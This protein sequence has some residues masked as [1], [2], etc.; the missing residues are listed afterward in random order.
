MNGR[1]DTRRVGIAV[2]SVIA[3]FAFCTGASAEQPPLR[4]V[5]TLDSASVQYGDPVEATVEVDYRPGTI[6]PASI[7]IEPSF[8]PYVATS[9]PVVRR[10]RP[11][12]F[13]STFTLLCLTEGCLPTEGPR[14]LHLEP[15]TV[16]AG[17]GAGTIRASGTWPTL[18]VSSR[19]TSADLSGPVRFRSPAGPPPPAYSIRPSVLTGGLILAAAICALAA[20]AILARELTKISLRSQEPRLSRLDLAIAYVRDSARRSGADRR[21]ALSLLAEATDE[22]EPLLAASAAEAAWAR[23]SPSPVGA[24]ELADRAAHTREVAE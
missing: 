22:R 12:V 10:P 3:L 15:A 11:G 21:R 16:T 19:L 7:R 23:P 6:D 1:P 9:E 5:A 4:V 17:T 13:T 8:V 18:R 24:T 14:M 20:I 2:A